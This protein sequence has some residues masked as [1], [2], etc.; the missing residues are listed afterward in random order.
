[1][2]Q[3]TIHK[4]IDDFLKTDI[5]TASVEVAIS[6]INH[7]ED[8]K[9]YFF[10]TANQKWLKWIWNNGLFDTLKIK[11]KDVTTYSY[12]LPELDYLTRMSAD[13]PEL[14]ADII[15]ATPILKDTFNPEVADR[16]FW[17]TGQLPAQQ[18]KIILPKILS[19]NWV[20]LMAPFNR[21]GYEYQKIVDKLL[22][23]KDYDSLNTLSQIIL[24]V[25]GE[26]EFKDSERFSISDKLF[27]L[28]DVSVTG[29]FNAV[30][31]VGNSKKEESLKIFLDVLKSIIDLG[32]DRDET[33]FDKSEPFYLL[34]VSI[35]TLELDT[36][37]RSHFREDIQNFIASCKELIRDV[38]ELNKHNV[39]DLKTIYETYIVTLPDSLTCWRLKLYAITLFPKIFK[40]EIKKELFRVFNVGER[41][42]ELDAGAEYHEALI[43]SF[44]ALE[45]LVQREYVSKV[46]EY[47]G[48]SLIDKKREKYRKGDGLEIVTYIQKYLTPEEVV[49][50]E[51]TFGK[52]L[53]DGKITPHPSMGP[54]STSGTISPRSPFNPGDFTIEE[55]IAHLKTDGSPSVLNEKYKDDDFFSPRGVEGLGDAI[56]ADFKIRKS[57]YLSKLNDFFDRETIFP[58]YVYSILRQIEDDLRAKDYFTDEQYIQIFNFFDIIRQ[59]G[60]VNEFQKSS[61][62]SYLSDWITVHKV[63]AD[64]LLNILGIIKNNQLFKDNRNKILPIIKYLLS[65]KSSPDVEDEKREDS[66]PS[67]VAINSVRGQAYRTFVQFVYND[68]NDSLAEDVKILYENIIDN[69]DSNAVRFTI[70]EFMSAFYFRDIQFIQGLLPKIFPKGEKGREK[71]YFSTWEGYLASSLYK[72]IFAELQPY[73][74]YAIKVNSKSYPDRKYRKGLDE[75]LAVHLALAYTHFDFKIGDPLFDL[76]WNTPN[77]NRHYEFVSFIGRSALTRSQAGDD[78]FEKNGVSKDKLIAFW[79]WMISTDKVIEPKAF[80]GF[81]FWINPDREILDTKVVIENLATTLLK[82]NGEIDWDHGLFQRIKVFAEI[83]PEKTLEIMK[84]L[85]LLNGD[86]NPHHRMYF[87]A[88][89]KFKEPL[90]IIAK[91]PALKKPVEDFINSLIEKG[92]QTFWSLKDVIN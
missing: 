54:I 30:V 49:K 65:V 52:I 12:R 88:N 48:A 83:N 43:A 22:T 10:F 86:L 27:Y 73:Y 81:G 64:V 33:V 39:P 26:E 79:N 74:E 37:K 87:D 66:E 62:R 76:F 42:F 34:D 55:L 56:K 21:S 18:I 51:A 59:S 16:F 4:Q 77:E 31:E 28:H 50:A 67:H 70:G 44:A 69:E 32:K 82:S 3:L 40:E 63:M 38:L 68:G 80:S 6:L 1:M 90:E 17:I 19:E 92:S 75:S 20:K 13:D 72:E 61:E 8:A 25:R 71:L 15:L 11:A 35:F 45:G 5:T 91:V 47:Y 58:G 60:E 89:T 57:E 14:V 36:N 2:N 78:W 24:T 53:E 46:I 29:I 9:R 7:N 23:E 41:H 84:H 85:L